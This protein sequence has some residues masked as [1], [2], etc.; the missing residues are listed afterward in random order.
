MFVAGLFTVFAWRIT[1][2]ATVLTEMLT[3][4]FRGVAT[5]DR[6]KMYWQLGRLQWCRAHLH[7]DLQALADSNDGMPDT[8]LALDEQVETDM[9]QVRDIGG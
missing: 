1:R 9:N 5:C 2:A 4:D 6:A 3:A 8:L 7:R